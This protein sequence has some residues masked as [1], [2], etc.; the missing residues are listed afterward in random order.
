MDELT[1]LASIKS[2][3]GLLDKQPLRKLKMKGKRVKPKETD[4]SD[5]K[6]DLALTVKLNKD[7]ELLA[8]VQEYEF[9]PLDDKARTNI[10]IFK[11]IWNY[12]WMMSRTDKVLT[13]VVPSATSYGTWIMYE[14]IKTIQ[15]K[16]QEPILKDWVR[17]FE[18]KL[19]TVYDGIYCEFIPWENF[20][21]DWTDIDNANSAIWIKHWDRDEYIKSHELDGRYDLSKIPEYK[22]F[23]PVYSAIDPR[24]NMDDEDIVTEIKYYNVALDEYIILANGVEVLRSPLPYKHKELP[25]GLFYDYKVDDRIWGMWEPELLEEDE[26]Y[27][28]KL[29]SLSIDVIKAQMWIVLMENDIDFDE[30]TFEYGTTSYT[31]V[32][33][34]NAIKFFSPSIST[35]SI[36]NAEAKLDNDI[37]WK[38][39]IDIKSQVFAPGE[40]A[41]RTDAKME[42]SK[43]KI[44]LN[45]KIN[46]FDFFE[47]IG[48]LRTSNIQLIMSTWEKQIPIKGMDV[49]KRGVATAT[50]GGYGFITTKP[51]Y[52]EGAFNLIPITDS[53]LWN[54]K[55]LN[56]R[57]ALELD[58]IL[59]NI[60]WSD[61]RPV[62]AWEKRVEKLCEVFEVDYEKLTASVDAQ[63]KP[64][65]ILKELQNETMWVP[66]DTTNPANPN[67]IPPEQRSGATKMMSWL[68]M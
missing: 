37:I 16:V 50:N 55:D 29:R 22:D 52:V 24:H 67:F 61:G 57:R 26:D 39:G 19:R 33:D 35:N 40:T 53:I 13:Q 12:R 56:K 46:A 43:K 21:I 34:I 45:L 17:T 15:K 63:K 11:T 65:D 30:S 41:K 27:K 5:I 54:T 44:N 66:N 7:A 10:P 20:Y 47:R 68:S 58:S 31:R 28:D 48:R 23:L 4:R 60:V 62:V 38:T 64:E 1:D 18:E 59:W 9:M 49:D 25:F 6:T 36:D 8:G 42:V 32:D 51:E 2:Q 3:D 14:G